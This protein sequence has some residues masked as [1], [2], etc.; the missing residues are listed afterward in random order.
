MS[1]LLVT[2]LL[3]LEMFSMAIVRMMAS[4]ISPLM[5]MNFIWGRKP[6]PTSSMILTTLHAS[7]RL[8]LMKRRLGRLPRPSSPLMALVRRIRK[9]R[10]PRRPRR[11][12]RLIRKSIKSLLSVQPRTTK[13][14]ILSMK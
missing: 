6:I 13:N 3:A 9:P 4:T 12:R 8:I 14:L 11:P 7:K 2:T 5:R 1:I 10:K